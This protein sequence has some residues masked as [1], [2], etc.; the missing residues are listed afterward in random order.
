[1]SREE[2]RK[3]KVGMKCSE[4]QVLSGCCSREKNVNQCLVYFAYEKYEESFAN[5]ST[6][7]RRELFEENSRRASQERTSRKECLECSQDHNQQQTV[8]VYFIYVSS[9]TSFLPVLSS[10]SLVSSSTSF[11]LVLLSSLILSSNGSQL[12]SHDISSL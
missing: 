9:S 7:S 6:S 11:L 1:M 10:S 5:F 12:T 4:M 3:R 8:F 2:E